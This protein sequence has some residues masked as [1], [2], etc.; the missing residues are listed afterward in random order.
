MDAVPLILFIAAIWFFVA[1]RKKG[2]AAAGSDGLKK[3]CLTC[4]MEAP[5]GLVPKGHGFI[6]LVMW[7][8]FIVPG[9]I[10]SIWRRSNPVQ[11][12]SVCHATNVVPQNAP[13]AVLHRQA[14]GT[15]S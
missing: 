1:K 11:C 7:L 5:P 6:E 4:G 3:H 2:Q 10:Y 15:D 14:L 9:L 13:A 8:C 12:C